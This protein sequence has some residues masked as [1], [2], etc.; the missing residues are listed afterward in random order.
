MKILWFLQSS[1]QH[2]DNR[3]LADQLRG[4]RLIIW[5]TFITVSVGL[6]WAYFAHLD[7]ITRAPG[8]VIASSRTQLIQSQ[9]GG[10]LEALLV[11]EGDVVVA[12]QV[13][14]RFERTRVESS[15]LESRAKMAG[16]S[17]TLARLR[18]EVFGGVPKY[19][20]ELRSFPDFVENQNQ[21]LSKRRTALKEDVDALESM[22]ALA[23]QE[24]DMNQPLVKSGDVSLTEV[25]RLQRQV[26]D[27][28]AQ[29]TNKRNKYFQ[30]AQ[31]E[32][33]KAEEDLAAASQLM[34]QR[35]DQLDV[36]EMRSPMRGTVKNV[37]ITTQGGVIRAGEEVMQIVPL[38][39]DLVIE[40]KVSS[41]DIGFLRLGM[42]ANI[43]I[44]AYDY[45]IYGS[46]PGKLTFI[47]ADTISENLRQNEQPYYRVH[48][49]TTLKQFS[50]LP[51]DAK[52]EIQPGMTSTI[53]VKTGRKSV[54][55]YMTKPLIKTLSES[56]G[57]R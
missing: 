8:A 43:K 20:V 34:V 15:Y 32:L 12:N 36:T 24:L 9:D 33:N 44:D 10:K 29:I 14:A 42:E 28:Q 57:E 16:L 17:A 40:A 55:Q 26:A 51:A 39:D 21:L 13:L 1:D 2:P 5:I 4:S 37:R 50:N 19:A 3:A 45:T 52:L 48:I 46:L 41:A 27:F 31:A 6:G 25:L 47:G 35:K 53:E 11:K 54:L 49:R 30:D 56:M 22:K 23:R 7:Q 18:A 38:E